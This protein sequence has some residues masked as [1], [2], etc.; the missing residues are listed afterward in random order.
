[1]SAPAAEVR[2][3]QISELERRVGAERT[4]IGRWIRSGKFPAPERFGQRRVW[5]LDVLEAWECERAA[6]GA[7]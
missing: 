6:Q 7:L 2:R 1:M 4:T 3:L 5:R